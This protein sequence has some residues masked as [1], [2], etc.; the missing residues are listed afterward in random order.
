MTMEYVCKL[1]GLD[2]GTHWI[3]EWLGQRWSTKVAQFLWSSNSIWCSFLCVFLVSFFDHRLILFLFCFFYTLFVV[4]WARGLAQQ[5]ESKPKT[6]SLTFFIIRDVHEKK[7]TSLSRVNNSRRP[8]QSAGGGA[9]WG[10][11]VG[12]GV[13]EV[14]SG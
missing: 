6:K 14:R 12:E 4:T 9:N 7:M 10:G 5:P 1:W 13:S 3:S 8:K 2:S 11:W